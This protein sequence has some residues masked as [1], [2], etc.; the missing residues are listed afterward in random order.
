MLATAVRV[1]RGNVPIRRLPIAAPALRLVGGTNLAAAR[2]FG[3]A[4]MRTPRKAREFTH[5]DR[6]GDGGAFARAAGWR[7]AVVSER[8][9]AD[10]RGRRPA[11]LNGVP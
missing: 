1:L 3:Y 10:T 2:A 7:P 8:G 11:A 4:P 9:L 6:A 5:A